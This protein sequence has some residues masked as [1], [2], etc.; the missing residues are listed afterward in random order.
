[1]KIVFSAPGL[2]TSGALAVGVLEGG[3]LTPSAKQ[4]DKKT[5]GAVK[6]A[7]KASRFN[8]KAGQKLMIV[9]PFFAAA[10]ITAGP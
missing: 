1:M 8:G 7:I 3:L 5:S 6:R 9:A 2:A 10:S 4:V